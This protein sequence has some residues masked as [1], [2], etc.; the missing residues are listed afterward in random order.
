MG[1]G[2]QGHSGGMKSCDF[3]C[4]RHIFAWIH[5]VWAICRQNGLGV[6]PPEPRGEK[7]QKVSTPIGMM[8]RR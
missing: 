3:Y 4:K 1:P 6:W 7:S 2:D 8:C 5:V